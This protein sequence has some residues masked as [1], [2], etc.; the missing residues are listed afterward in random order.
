A[1]D[2]D[3]GTVEVDAEA[4][5]DGRQT[6]GL[7][8]AIEKEDGRIAD[9]FSREIGPT[10]IGFDAEHRPADLPIDA[11][12]PS[13]ERTIDRNGTVPK[14]R[15]RG[16]QVVVVESPAAPSGADMGADIETGPAEGRRRRWR[17]FVWYGH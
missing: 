5:G 1:F 17:R 9:A 3:Q 6:I 14:R 2:V 10:A 13:G 7:R 16:R 15:R 11:D 8:R 12:L 4:A